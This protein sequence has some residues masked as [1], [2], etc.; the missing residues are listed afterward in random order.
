MKKTPKT[1]L[2]GKMARQMMAMVLTTALIAGTAPAALAV[3]ADG[4]ENQV[5]SPEETVYVNS[6]S[7]TAREI[8]FNDHWRFFYGEQQ[9][10]QDPTFNDAS[11]KNIDL[12]HDYSI[13][14]SYTPSGEAESGYLPGGVGWYRKTFSVDSS[15]KDTKRLSIHFDGV[16]MNAEVYLN[17]TKLGEHPYGYTP[18]SFELPADQL[19][20]GENVL[21]VRVNNPIPSSR[22]YSGSGIYRDVTL[23]VTDPVHIAPYGVTVTTPEYENTGS[24]ERGKVNVEVKIANHGD[25]AADNLTVVNTI[26]EQGTAVATTTTPVTVPSVVVKGEQTIQDHVVVS[27]PKQWNVWDKGTPTLYTLKTEIKQGE[28]V[29]DTVETKFGFRYFNMDKDTGFSLN[30]EKMKLRGVCMHHD[31]GALGAEAWEDAIRRQVQILKEM[32]C[33]AIR[34]TH[35][36]AAQVLID[37]CNEEGMLVVEEVF[38]TWSNPK[39]GNSN[40]YAKYFNQSI[41]SGNPIEGGQSNM[42]WA[43]FDVKAMVARDK[44]APSIV[45]WSLGNEIFEGISG[46]SRN[47]PQIADNLIRWVGE[48]DHSR[49]VTIGDNRR[50][51]GGGDTPYQVMTKIH[52]ANNSGSGV[53]GGVVGFNYGGGNEI[54]AGHNNGWLMY[55][56][57]TAS[58]IN[59]RGV[60]TDTG[61]VDYAQGQT[62]DQRLTSYDRSRV[63]WGAVASDAWWRTIKDDFNAGE[64]IWTGFDYLGEPTPWNK[65]NNGSTTGDFSVAPKSSYFGIIDTTGFPKDSFWLYQ[66][67]WNEKVNTLHILPTWDEKDVKKDDQGNV[68]VVVY[69]DAPYIE[70]LKDG[71]VIGTATATKHTTNAQHQYQT[72]DNGTGC[73]KTTVE[74]GVYDGKGHLTSVNHPSVVG[75]HESLYATFK[76]PYQEGTLT[77][78][79]YSEAPAP[80]QQVDSS[81]LISNTRGR[82]MVKTTKGEHQLVAQAETKSI[83]ADGKSLCYI[84]IDVQDADGQFV[85]SA[86]PQ[87]TLS[88][89][90][91]GRIV[92]VDNG[93]QADHTPYQ[94]LTRKAERGKLLVIVQSTEKAGSF[95]VT[96][97]APGLTAASATVTTTEDSSAAQQVKPASVTYSRNHTVKLGYE[98]VLP[99]SINVILTDGT[100]ESCEVQWDKTGLN[101]QQVGTTVI[102][103]T[104]RLKDGQT[105]GINANITVI[106]EVEALQNYS[107][108]VKKGA[109]SANLPAFLPVVTAAGEISKASFPVEWDTSNLHLNTAGI[110]TVTGTANAFGKILNPTATIRV[111]E[112]QVELGGNVMNAAWMHENNGTRI[113]DGSLN[114]LRDGK[115]GA[116]DTAWTKTGS[117]EF[118]YD[119]AQNLTKAVFFFKG[120][121]APAIQLF[122]SPDGS[123]WNPIQVKTSEAKANGVTTVTCDFDMVSA[124]WLRAS[125]TSNVQLLETELY[126]GTPSFAIGSEAA[127]ESLTV[128]GYTANSGIL[129]NGVFNVP[130]E[131]DLNSI[132]A[133]GKDNASVTILPPVNQVVYIVL[134]SEDHTKTSTFVIHLNN[135]D[136][137]QIENPEESGFDYDYQKTTASALSYHAGTPEGEAERAIDHDPNTWWHSRWGDAGS[138]DTDLSNQPEKRYLQLTLDTPARL[139][140]LRYLPRPGAEN[141]TVLQYRV[142]VSQDEHTWTTAASGTWTREAKWQLAQF[143]EPVMAKYVRLYGEK[144]VS[145]GKPNQF[146]SAAEV[147]VCVDSFDGPAVILGF[148]ETQVETTV[149]REPV[150]PDKVIAKLS[151]GSN[152]EMSV[153]WPEIKPEQ[154]AEANRFTVEGTVEGTSFKPQAQVLVEG[155]VSVDSIPLLVVPQGSTPQL[156]THVSAQMASGKAQNLEV[157]WDPVPQLN[158]GDTV[159]VQG[160]IPSYN[161]YA[162][163]VQVTMVEITDSTQNLAL[164]SGKTG[165]PMAIAL[166]S[167]NNGNPY[168]ATDGNINWNNSGTKDTWCDW[169]RD[170]YYDQIPNWMG[171]VF[172]SD[173]TVKAQM[174]NCVK[175]GFLTEAGNENCIGLPKSY[176]I[177]YYTG[178]ANPALVAENNGRVREWPE[179]N[180]LKDDR[181]WKTVSYIGTKPT[182]ADNQQL[183][184]IHFAPV[185]TSAIRIKMHANTRQW[186]A[187]PAFEVYGATISDTT[188]R[189]SQVE[190]IAPEAAYQN[191]VIDLQAK[192]SLVNTDPS[193]VSLLAEPA[194]GEAVCYVNDIEVGREPVNGTSTVTFSQI[195][196]TTEKGFKEGE[197][198][199]KVVYGGDT[200]SI[201][202]VKPSEGTTT[203][204][205]KVKALHTVTFD[206]M[207][208]TLTDA[209]SVQIEDGKPVAKPTDP[210]RDN[211]DFAGW[212]TEDTYETKYQFT[213]AVTND[214]T[215]YAKWTD[216]QN[217][218]VEGKQYTVTFDAMGGTLSSA[219]SVQVEE[220][221]LVAKPADPTHENYDFAGWYTEST[222]ETAYQFTEAVTSDLTLYAKWTEKS[223]TPPALTGVTISPDVLTLTEGQ[224]AKLTVSLLPAGAQGDVVWRVYPDD[225]TISI[226]QNGMVIANREGR[227]TVQVTVGN[228]SAQSTVFVS[229]P[230]YGGDD[231]SND[232]DDESNSSHTVKHPDGSITTT[233]TDRWGTITETTKRKDGSVQIVETQKDGTVTK[234]D[235]KADGSVQIVET[236]K[237]GVV[238]TMKKDPMGTAGTVVTD[239]HG[240]TTE[241]Y[242]EV[243][244]ESAD[245]AK[246]ENQ[247]VQ[248][249]VEAEVYL[250]SSAAPVIHLDLPSGGAKVEIPVKYVTASTVPVIVHDDGSET[251]LK[252]SFVSGSGIVMNLSGGINIKL[253]NNNKYF[254]DVQDGHWAKNAVDFATSRELFNGVSNTQFAP[255][256]PTTRGQLMAVLAR[257]DDADTTGDAMQ[258][259]MDWAMQKGISDG[260]NPEQTMTRQQLATMLWRYAGMP[261]SDAAME[262]SDSEAI[263]DYAKTAMNW[264]VENGIL[265]GYADGSLK[266]HATASRAHV[267]VMVER[268]IKAI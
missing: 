148:Q 30:G 151:D 107:A 244:A 238:R 26:L 137:N 180:P 61:N 74:R 51:T 268:F 92:G 95:T 185:M 266:P 98:P 239:R 184:E 37:V 77:A 106:D 267:V 189:E 201:V 164:N 34:V 206:A 158:P 183:M 172:G 149:G 70:L 11:W 232:R 124:V 68:E 265:T 20:P 153:T 104:L 177:E 96:A 235:K 228:Y 6:Y 217:P 163:S 122:S 25:A 142:D 211:F 259:G 225:G 210:T 108:A 241:I 182:P 97:T 40:D 198:T 33:N 118:E 167:E 255:N 243:S 135:F 220:G 188:Q 141:G 223:V 209:E 7:G 79:A 128:A 28:Q 2:R 123:T 157:T 140:A 84:D 234:T 29:L 62:G 253:V 32:G 195:P 52:G 45:M 5:S 47:Y 171:V 242:A 99:S 76:V 261:Q 174:V 15:W 87:I 65:T 263:A 191:D 23:V 144:T 132:T 42:T 233:E 13:E 251:I 60:Y 156:P 246:R 262:Y 257:L 161:N 197:N 248:L 252:K 181:N 216:K 101:V 73:F 222:Y 85:N 125:F 18:F 9:G 169:E 194:N 162:V 114:Y 67:L 215:L 83:T 138:G 80:G 19:L 39:N 131:A 139:N 165:L 8:N 31:Q 229:A 103:G 204:Q 59:S 113:T 94:S 173:N 190:V 55:G 56:S 17:G 117:L 54:P 127:L 213:E 214:F 86:E 69:S 58:A 175:V 193:T 147:R 48:V 102:R 227:V 115:K 226:N 93:R 66:S 133:K 43:E 129:G 203:M 202:G 38:D 207:G 166:Y 116:G 57:E 237:D 186:L 71:Q 50:Q 90:G 75:N 236:R 1:W 10:A 155:I 150:M 219:E 27:N 126:V 21:A 212:Y 264:A 14:Q 64:F 218:P 250:S 119:T 179:G 205:V 88:I 49:Y 53:K 260:S 35:N 230:S 245:L 134:G 187:I 24:A 199:I 120:D 152:A 41:G 130:A 192:I 22:W 143:D 258:K 256:A 231:S 112:G 178:P 221:K 170:K 121:A 154:Y 105:L 224:S 247:P 176:E 240:K 159:T 111:S 136:G 72:F 168:R 46:D 208:G 254:D 100:S 36:P 44:N 91:N 78:K 160:R 146:M 82:D 145:N 196:V 200:N 63:G 3:R 249:P 109:S 110:Y 12:P 16:Y 89:Q 4:I 81:K